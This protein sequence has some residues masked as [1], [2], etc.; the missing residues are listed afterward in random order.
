MRQESFNV[1]VHFTN[2]KVGALVPSSVHETCILYIPV[3]LFSFFL[4]HVYCVP[5]PFY[6]NVFPFNVPLVPFLSPEPP[7]NFN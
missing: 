2:P 3:Y 5:I 7:E 6:S 1:N 4:L